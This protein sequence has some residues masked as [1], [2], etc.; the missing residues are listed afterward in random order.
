M[1]FGQGRLLQLEAEVESRYTKR[2]KENLFGYLH[3]GA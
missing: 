3:P 1:Q 2:E